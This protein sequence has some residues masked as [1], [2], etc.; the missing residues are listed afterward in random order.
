M[1][2]TPLLL[3]L[4]SSL[5]GLIGGFLLLWKA[6]RVRQW[7]GWLVSF[8]A[9][10]ILAAAFLDLI[11]EALEHGE[12]RGLPLSSVLAWVLAGA[13]T[14]M[15][16]EKLLIWHHHSHTH[17]LDHD[18]THPSHLPT[19]PTV[20]PLI[21]VG[22]ALHNFLDGAVIAAAYLVS[23]PLAI[24]T[25][26]AVFAHEL[27]QEIGD[28]GILV[29]SGMRRKAIMLWNVVGAL[30]SPLGTVVMLTAADPFEAFEPLLLAFA[31]GNFIYIA[32]ADLLPSIQ[33]ERRLV[34]SLTQLGLLLVGVLVIWQIGVRLPHE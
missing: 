6:D 15:L 33:H 1:P 21:I 12:E 4:A 7:S 34:K 31:A 26:L 19:G 5:L 17:D 32:L 10:S 24:I 2:N 27:P 13:L 11:P 18:A 28:F 25:A 30:F 23:P 8:A 3:S 9:G 14:F 22:D 29:A 16:V 20:R